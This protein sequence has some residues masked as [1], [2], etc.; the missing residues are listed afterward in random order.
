MQLKWNGRSYRPVGN[1]IKVSEPDINDLMKPLSE[2]KGLGSAILTGNVINA[3]NPTGTPAPPPSPS[4]TPTLSL[5]PSP[6]PSATPCGQCIEYIVEVN[7]VDIDSATG[8]TG[9]FAFYNNKVA[10]THTPCGEPATEIY[11]TSAGTYTVCTDLIDILFT[12][13]YYIGNNGSNVGQIDY[14]GTGT[15]NGSSLSFGS[16]C[17]PTS[18]TPTPTLTQTPSPTPASLYTYQFIPCGD[19]GSNAFLYSGITTT[20]NIGDVYDISGSLS[21]YTG[22]ATLVIFSGTGS[23]YDASGVTF[24][25]TAGCPTPTPTPTI[26]PTETPTATP[27]PTPSSTPVPSGTTE[28][29]TYLASVLSAGGTGI[30]PTVSAATITLFTSLVSNNLW[31]S[32]NA[33]YPVLGGVQLSHAINAKSPGT[34]NLVFSGG[35]THN[36]SGMTANGT[37]GVANTGVLHSTLG[38]NSHVSVY[39]N[40]NNIQS[41]VDIG[42]LSG[43]G[44]GIYIQTRFTDIASQVGCKGINGVDPSGARNF[45]NTDATGHYIVSRNSATNKQIFKNGTLQNT[46]NNTQ[47]SVPLPIYIGAYNSD[48]TTAGYVNRQYSFATVGGEVN[49]AATTLSNIINTFQTSIGRNI[50]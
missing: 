4:V 38:N 13:L 41:G 25:L 50:Y 7:Q 6:T 48:G 3:K 30:T 18:P 40:T 19:D 21:G 44:F 49:T 31:D 39:N 14:S 16:C 35:W 33:F 1:Y 17:F 28:A 8:N 10:F 11:F 22:Y 46:Q 15:M 2:K 34:N 5:T 23:V 45:A 36:A 20:L 29:E 24:T 12:Q 9:G 42:C 27:T 43:S 32:L 47:G 26:T 37:N